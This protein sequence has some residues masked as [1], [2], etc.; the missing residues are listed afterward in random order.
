MNTM[1]KISV[2]LLFLVGAVFNAHADDA[3]DLENFYNS[4]LPAFQRLTPEASALGQYGKYHSSGFSGVPNIP[5]P[6]FS[7]GSGNFSLPAELCYDAS[8]IK[9][10]QQA[11]YVGL[12]WNLILGGSISQIVCGKNDFYDPCPYPNSELKDSVLPNIVYSPYFNGTFY[13]SVAFS[14][15]STLPST[16]FPLEED[17]RKYMIL[18]DVSN[19]TSVP[20]IFQ[21][22]F[23]GHSVSFI[24]ANGR[25]KIIGNDATAYKIDIETPGVPYPLSIRIT[26]D[27]GI[28]Y[29]FTAAPEYTQTDN[30]SY[31]LSEIQN[32]SGRCLVKFIYS[33]KNCNLLESYYETMGTND[34]NYGM[35][36]AS[37]AILETFIRKNYPSSLLYCIKAYY[38]D[39]IITDREIVKFTYGTRED[40]K[41]AKQ[42]ERITVTSK[43]DDSTI[44]HTVI[45]N[46]G[47]F[48]EGDYN[49]ELCSRYRYTDVYDYKR[50]KLTGV[51]V[52]GKEYSFGYESSSL[53]ARLSKSQDFWGYFNGKPNSEGLC[54]SPEYQFDS[55]GYLVGVESVG[56]ANRYAYES[57][58]KAGILNK[59]TYPTGGYTKFDF[60]INHF[61][62]V[63]GKY[64]YPSSYT[65]VQGARHVMCGTGYNGH[66]YNTTPDSTEFD[67]SHSVQA[68][69]YSNTPYRPSNDHY[70]KLYFTIVGK[71]SNGA[72]V[73]S[74]NYTKYNDEQD[75]NE[76]CLL[77]KGHYVMTSQFLVPPNGSPIG[78]AII[79]EMPQE[80]IQ[81]PS[82]ADISGKSF[83]G[84]LRIRTIENYDSDN[85]LLGYTRYKYDGGK[86]LIPTVNKEH[87]N[88]WYLFATIPADPSLYVIPSSMLCSFFFVTSNP[89]Y[90]AACSLGCP[91]VGYSKVTRE[92]YDKNGQ[93]MSY[94]VEKYHNQGYYNAQDKIFCVNREGLDGKLTESMT[95]SK[96]SVLMRKACYFYETHGANP[97]QSDV[98]FFPWTRCTELNP[99]NIN[100]NVVY[101]YSLFSI[102]PICSLLSSVTETDYTSGNAMRPVTTAYEYKDSIYRPACV[103]RTVGLGSNTG[104][105]YQTR[106]WYPGDTE[107]GNSGTSCL[108]DAHCVSEQVKAVE[109]RNGKIAG[110]YRNE[111]RALPDSLPVVSKSYSITH[112]QDEDLELDV[113]END[114]Y[115][116][117]R[118]YRKKD[119]TPVTL[120]WS[121]NHQCPVMEIV[122]KTCSDVQAISNVVSELEEDTVA[123]VIISK[124]E[125]LHAALRARRIMAT[126]YEYSPWHT[127]TCVIRP[128]GD[129][130][131]YSYDSYG[132]L[133][134]ISDVNNN[135]IQK[136]S[137]NYGTR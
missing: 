135:T 87:I 102:S 94:D 118:E 136:N 24:I 96:D 107:V 83:G 85:A 126:A 99:G 106:Y 55:E 132:R 97:S 51:T 40:I 20:D 6:L 39:T 71:D 13:P 105:T 130:T 98:V 5:V 79:V 33:E 78:G 84:G 127:V 129:K 15:V 36:I 12:A 54:A 100:L 124:T 1:D 93:L 91:Y 30:V 73:F 128:N 65:Y 56:Q 110:G 111:Y 113:S 121:Y 31:N 75:F 109:Y 133:E 16:N 117:I 22:S 90:L 63:W 42:L 114:A 23:C 4:F 34:E 123:T 134:K 11:T 89:T 19:G 116:N 68:E 37:Q 41:D 101:K 28:R 8:G 74:K 29:M 131:R 38:P 7:I 18:Q 80:H 82:A 47:Y 44:L 17:R 67:V 25:A 32:S 35:P 46:Y 60:E 61:N 76:S 104:E 52:D 119:G 53:P 50:L 103:T 57:Y 43:N 27:H 21:A 120:I 59:I 92:N 45:F 58:C 2:V 72:T 122:G 86:L 137:Y 64:Y 115:G 108:T 26:D 14:S 66:G 49:S 3:Q 62:D 88:M 48:T 70:Y 77:P 95:Y 69:I 125:S 10:D 9:V 81:V 112:S